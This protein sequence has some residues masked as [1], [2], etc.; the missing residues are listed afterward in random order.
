MGSED[1][2]KTRTIGYW[3]TTG[4]LA[5]AFAAGGVVDLIGGQEMKEGMAHLGY[6]GYFAS[7][8]GV[9][10]VLGAVALLVPRFPRLKEWAYAG[11][12]FDLTG[13]AVSHAVIG[14]GVAKIVTPLALFVLAAVSWALRPE[15]RV[16]GKIAGAKPESSKPSLRAV[17][18]AA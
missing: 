16:L 11:I 13:A 10:K 8:L 3:A 1:T 2:M 6:P 18:A 9:W 14:D 17:P 15:A 5:A 12:A 4:L 7:I